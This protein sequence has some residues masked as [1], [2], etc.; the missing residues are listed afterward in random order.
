MFK[1]LLIF[2]I[3]KRI[4]S[5][6][7][8]GSGRIML[9]TA[10]LTIAV[11]VAVMAMTINIIGGFK[12][13]ISSK[14]V[15]FASHFTITS[16]DK[17]QEMPISSDNQYIEQIKE[18][19]FVKS[20]APY[21]SKGGV[22]K[23]SQGAKG[24]QLKGVDSSYDFSFIEKSMVEGRL[25]AFSNDEKTK[26]VI[27]S[28]IISNQMLLNIGD[29]F[30]MMFISGDDVFRDRLEVVGV[31]QTSLAEFDGSTIIGDI[32]VVSRV[33]GYRAG[34]IGGYE[35]MSDNF[36]NIDDYT[37]QL[38]DVLFENMDAGEPLMLN[39]V[40]SDYVR[41]F[42][43]LALQDT[44]ILVIMVVM[45]FVAAFSM[46]AMML[47]IL[48]EKSSMI[49][50]LKTLGMKD[51]S[52]QRLFILRSSYIVAVGIGIGVLVSLI[53]SYIQLYFKPLKLS[54]EAYFLDYVPIEINYLYLCGVAIY[55]FVALM[56]LQTLP[57]RVISKM[58]PHESI[59]GAS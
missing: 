38:E 18:L 10:I 46:I 58:A 15:G 5:L 14:V 43:W 16:L 36:D 23:S 31:Y 28:K 7:S 33:S 25:P 19:D 39:S 56:L 26:E 12:Q 2:F 30:E 17:R 8:E 32:Q 13:E 11:S 42:D 21:T 24:V 9:R 59:K 22:L 27:I 54:A 6:K 37:V 29:K 4:S 20:V 53:L 44:N 35:I 41:I 55:S 48:I 45:I 34:E 51:G 50:I 57:V 52:L 49:G 47:I 1:K 40:K 3:A